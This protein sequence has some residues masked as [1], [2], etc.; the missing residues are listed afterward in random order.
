MDKDQL[1]GNSDQATDFLGNTQSFDCM[2]CAIANRKIEAPGG[3]IY[4]G[5]HAVIA[6][7][8]EVPIPGFLIVNAK[9]HIRS[10]SELDSAER[11]EVIDIVACAE[12]ALRELGVADEVTVVQEERSKHLHVWVFPYHDW[13]SE[14]FGKGIKYLRDIT[15]YARAHAEPSVLDETMATIEKVRKYFTEH[16]ISE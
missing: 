14:Q 2:G 7:D 5:D 8:P 9:R 15:E 4:E 13:M 10:F 6:G 12:K 16:Q 1:A 11:H 3:L